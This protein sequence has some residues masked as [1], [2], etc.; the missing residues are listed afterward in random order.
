[1]LLTVEGPRTPRELAALVKALMDWC[2]GAGGG[3]LGAV[4][5]QVERRYLITVPGVQLD[6]VLGALAAVLPAEAGWDGPP[7]ARVAG[8]I[9]ARLPQDQR[10]LS[11]LLASAWVDLCAAAD[12]E[13]TREYEGHDHTPRDPVAEA[14]R[15]LTLSGRYYVIAHTG[16]GKPLLSR[17]VIGL[18]LA[19]AA[20]AELLIAGRIG[21]E[22]RTHHVLRPPAGRLAP[23]SEH[24]AGA[25]WQPAPSRAA[26]RVLEETPEQPA[27]LRDH[28]VALSTRI[29]DWVCTDLVESG[30][31]GPETHGV[32][33]GR[34]YY[35]P[36]QRG[37]AKAIRA[38]VGGSLHNDPIPVADAVLAELV[39]ATA[40]DARQSGDWD[41]LASMARGDALAAARRPEAAARLKL[42]VDLT[43]A[44]VDAIVTSPGT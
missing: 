35:A 33:R 8:W 2:A 25:A 42:L 27:P 15:R 9:A 6:Q 23:R 22:I 43:A 31:V 38:L 44:E 39:T 28:L 30:L 11:T 29:E 41:R 12:A 5:A 26:E 20:I 4:V 16:H 34:V 17:P 18:G 19:A 3:D 40:L 21:L 24:E 13:A 37:L 1:M 36:C 14:V 7:A 32:L 10:A